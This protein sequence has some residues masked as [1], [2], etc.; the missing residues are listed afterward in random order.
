MEKWL[1]VQPVMMSDEEEIEGKFKVH[2]PE[3]HSDDFNDFMDALDARALAAQGKA[4]PRIA[5]YSGTPCKSQPPPNTSLWMLST[6]EDHDS[7][8]LAPESPDMFVNQD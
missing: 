5:R 6:T 7:E 1:Q 8:I 2:R 3:W 4:R